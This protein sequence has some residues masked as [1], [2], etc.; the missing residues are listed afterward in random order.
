MPTA[1]LNAVLRDVVESNRPPSDAR[2]RPVRLFYAT[3]VE[4]AP[5]TI[6]IST[7]APRSVTEPYKR[8]LLNAF[9]KSL[10]FTEVP[11]RLLVRGRS[12]DQSSPET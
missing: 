2:G 8:Y 1:R 11:I 5:P 6:V 4:A 12:G 3:Q 9:R 10:P 7:S